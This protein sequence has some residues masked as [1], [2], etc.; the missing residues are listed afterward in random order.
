MTN[1]RNL[2]LQCIDS[3]N[4]L[5]W[6]VVISQFCKCT[7]HYECEVIYGSVLNYLHLSAPS[8]IGFQV[9][10]TTDPEKRDLKAISLKLQTGNFNILFSSASRIH[11]FSHT[12]HFSQLFSL[13]HTHLPHLRRQNFFFL[14]IYPC[15]LFSLINQNKL[16]QLNFITFNSPDTVYLPKVYLIH[17][18]FGNIWFILVTLTE[19]GQWIFSSLY[20]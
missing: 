3:A 12:S 6:L 9:G 17:L 11:T 20:D 14:N 15:L 13:I 18:G 7:Q 10:Q 16:K 19:T 8:G 4:F 1:K 2:F 5:S